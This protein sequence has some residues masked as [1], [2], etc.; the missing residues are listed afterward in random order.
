MRGS[1][2]CRTHRVDSWVEG[3]VRI[4]E[5]VE[6]GK[7]LSNIPN[8]IGEEEPLNISI[9]FCHL[10]TFERFSSYGNV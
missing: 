1:P 5:R 6:K 3:I 7:N 10:R 8:V 2:I 9:V 4:A